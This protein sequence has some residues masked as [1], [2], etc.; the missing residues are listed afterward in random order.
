VPPW[1]IILTVL[2]GVVAITGLIR[3]MLT[4]LKRELR[5]EIS[6]LR[7]ELKEVRSAVHGLEVRFAAFEGR[8]GPRLPEPPAAPAE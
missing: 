8:F 7:G 2:G 4:D 1:Q 3:V 5:G 6:E